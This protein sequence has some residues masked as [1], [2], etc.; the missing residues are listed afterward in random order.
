VDEADGDFAGPWAHVARPWMAAETG[1]GEINGPVPFISPPFI[2]PILTTE[3]AWA[4]GQRLGI[5]PTIQ[6]NGNYRYVIPM[7]R[8]VGW[9]G[10]AAGDGHA[11]YNIRIVVQPGTNKVV[12]AFPD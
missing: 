9:Q 1:A 7:G 6:P 12:T 3:E 10:G 8:N 5:Q 2:S 4:R 11:L